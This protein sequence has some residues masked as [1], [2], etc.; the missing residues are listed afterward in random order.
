MV[1]ED[2][3]VSLPV[4]DKLQDAALL[5]ARTIRD[6]LDNFT[7]LLQS[8]SLGYGFR[9]PTIL[10]KLKAIGYELPPNPVKEGLN[11]FLEQ[12]RQVASF[13]AQREIKHQARIPIP[14]SFKLVGVPD[15]GP[16]YEGKEGYENI[17]CLAEGRIAACVQ[18]HGEQ[19]VWLEGA[20]TIS[21]SPIAHIGD[22]EVSVYRLPFSLSPFRSEERRVG[23]ECRSR[24]S[25]YH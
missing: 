12:L 5:E 8:H 2:Q 3:H 19:P 1:L 11:P 23:K 7:Q 22:G 13:D 14:G 4:F 9:L 18:N 17:F 21:R 24:W 10:E 25:P 16:T 6:S 20:C 15:E